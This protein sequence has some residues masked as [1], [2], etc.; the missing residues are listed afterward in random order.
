[1][2]QGL[3]TFVRQELATNAREAA[4]QKVL[5]YVRRA[6][7]RMNK[8]ILQQKAGLSSKNFHEVIQSLSEDGRLV[9]RT[10]TTEAGQTTVW[11]RLGEEEGNA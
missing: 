2:K 4:H 11:V 5:Q 7:G 9:E 6:G 3:V 8:R 10:E 1:M